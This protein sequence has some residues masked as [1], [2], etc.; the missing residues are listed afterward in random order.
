[1]HKWRDG[2]MHQ[3]ARTI[4][5]A[6]ADVLAFDFVH[7]VRIFE[8]VARVTTAV[9]L[10]TT[11]AVFALD[12]IDHDGSTRVEKCTLTLDVARAVGH[13]DYNK[14]EGSSEAFDL[15]PGQQL[16]IEHKTAAAGGA[17]A[18]AVKLG[19]KYAILSDATRDATYDHIHTS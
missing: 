8:L 2:H 14:L 6:A 11:D 19:F 18:G 5:T 10:G 13:R 16:V 3:T 1:M 12:T 4:T 7:P 9:V 17:A 15:Q